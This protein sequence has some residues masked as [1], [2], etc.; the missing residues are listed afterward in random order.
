VGNLFNRITTDSF[1]GRIPFLKGS[2]FVAVIH[3][4]VFLQQ[5]RKAVIL[6]VP[7]NE[8]RDIGKHQKIKLLIRD[9]LSL[10]RAS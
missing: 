7:L 9:S 8:A 6:L 3:V 2:V 5:L 10:H 1:S 4:E